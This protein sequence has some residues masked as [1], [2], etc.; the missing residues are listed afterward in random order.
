[1]EFDNKFEQNLIKLIDKYGK[2]P[3][4]IY[5]D[6]EMSEDEEYDPRVNTHFFHYEKHNEEILAFN[7]DF[8][9]KKEKSNKCQFKIM[10]FDDEIAENLRLIN[11]HPNLFK[12]IPEIDAESLCYTIN[13]LRIKYQTEKYHNDHVK[14]IMDFTEELFK[15]TYTKI[16]GLINK[17][18]IDFES[19]WY[20][21]DKVDTIYKMKHCNEDICF[22]YKCFYLTIDSKGNDVLVLVGNIIIPFEGELNTYE[23]EYQFR[24]FTGNKKL[25]TLAISIPTESELQKF[26]E[27]GDKILGIYKTFHHMELKGKQYIKDTPDIISRIKDERVIVDYDGMEKYGDKPYVFALENQLENMEDNDKPVIY[28]F[29]SIYNLGITKEWGI[30]HIK[31]LYEINYNAQSFDYLVL[32]QEKK[33]LIK[34]LINNQEKMTSYTDFIETKGKGLMFLLSGSPGSGKTLTVE[35]ISEYM[36][37]PLY[38]INCGDLGVDL[39]NLESILN[40]VLIYS[41]LWSAIILIDE[42]DIFIEERSTGDLVRNAMV[43]MFLKLLEYHNGIIFLTTNRLASIDSAIK[44]RINLMLSYKDLDNEKRLQIW[45]ALCNKWDIK[46]KESTFKT[47][48][49]YKLNGREIRNYIKLVVVAHESENKGI[50]DVSFIKELKKCFRI[51]DEFTAAIGKNPSLYI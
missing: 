14:R 17:G 40:T 8:K 34:A 23:M 48:S 50:S 6:Q 15:D 13:D 36:K 47:L 2:R 46:L 35:T 26:S 19:L 33:T 3:F 7:E 49:E 30:T 44:S 11:D 12:P 20:Y 5:D 24:S 10:I 31:N 16:N 28:P 1:M 32:E 25:N 45:K 27:Y 51:T 38:S 9:I 39:N 37:K 21:L 43:S 18:V 22:K 29:A 4:T 41:K 42:A